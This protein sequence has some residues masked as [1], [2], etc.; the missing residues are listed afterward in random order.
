MGYFV[1]VDLSGYADKHISFNFQLAP[2]SALCWKEMKLSDQFDSS[3]R[4]KFRPAY[5]FSPAWGWMNDPNGMV[6]KDGEYHLFYQYNPY[7]SMW[8]NMHWGHAISKDLIHW[9]HQ[10][11]A[12]APD[13]LGTIF[14]GSCVVDK[15]NT[16]GFGA[17]AIVAFYTSASD[18]QVQ[19][20][21]YSLDNGGRSRNMTGIRFLLLR[22]VISVTRKSSGIRNPINGSWYS[23]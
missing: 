21:A 4:E 11:V 18:R 16:A 1:P 6:Y 15:D 19:S 23:P 10:P 3:N 14:S 12:I 8:G 17:G 20:M 7:G 13:A 5:H 22:N 9:E 2:E